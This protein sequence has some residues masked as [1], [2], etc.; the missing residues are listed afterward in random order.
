MRHGGSNSTPTQPQLTFVDDKRDAGVTFGYRGR[1]T[2]LPTTCV[3]GAGSSGIAAVKALA[4]HGFDVTAYDKS[5]RVGGNWVW[6]NN[7]GMSSAYRSLHINT[8][9]ER[10]E[11][12]DFPMPKSY[13]DFPHHTHI[14]EYFDDYVDHFGIRDRIRFGT[15]VEHAARRPDGVLGGHARRR[16]H[17]PLRRAGGRQRP[18]LGRALARAGV[19]RLRRLRGRAD[20]L[21]RLQG[22]RPRPV[23]RQDRRRARDGQLGDG[24]RGRGEL[25]RR[26]HLP[27]RAPRRPHPP[28]VPVRQA[29]RPA[30]RLD[31]D[32]V[33]GPPEALPGDAEGLP[34][35]HGALRAAQARPP[36][37]RRPPDHLRRHPLADGARHDHREAEHRVADAGR[38]ALHRR[39]RGQGRRRRLLH[40]LQGHVPVL[41]RGLPLARR[42][43][44]CRCTA[45]PST[46][47]SRTCSSSGCCSRSARSCRSR[48]R[49]GSG[50]ATTSP[51]AT[52]CPRRP[53]CA[54]TWRPSGAA[55]SSATWPPSATRCR[56]T[57]TTGWRRW[58]RSARRGRSGR[59]A[60]LPVPRRADAPVAA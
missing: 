43:T 12:S 31:E 54:P 27:G 47:T 8:S 32:P 36:L 6:G 59:T 39:L 5:D 15:G 19:P 13:P 3:I 34:R 48:R 17:P 38:R 52:R 60:Q 51:A 37:R 26:A 49:R 23:P 45:A 7:N 50:S 25:R 21:A 58:P 10:M 1:M 33:R 56:S 2:S 40:R 53:T 44:T 35:R 30:R 41:R 20:A 11:Y 57:S 9:R 14:A 55:C 16:Q 28:Q 22:R 4:G 24:H 29:D 46:P 42:T 18:P